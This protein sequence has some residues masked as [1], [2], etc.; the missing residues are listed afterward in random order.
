MTTSTLAINVPLIGSITQ[1]DT[2]DY[3]FI[4]ISNATATLQ[5]VNTSTFKILDVFPNPVSD[6]ANFQFVIGKSE[7]ISFYILDMFG[8]IVDEKKI[9]SNYG[10]NKFDVDISKLP[11]GIYTYCFKNSNTLISKKLIV[12]NF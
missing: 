5:H 3:Y 4:D 2:V 8:N 6:N 11:T 10:V 7:N 12:S 9:N 1:L